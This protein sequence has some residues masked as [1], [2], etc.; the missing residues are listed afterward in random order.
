VTEHGR[1]DGLVHGGMGVAAESEEAMCFSCHSETEPRSPRE[2]G[3]SLAVKR[4]NEERAAAAC[5]ASIS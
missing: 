5:E 4:G 2:Q 1:T 3:G